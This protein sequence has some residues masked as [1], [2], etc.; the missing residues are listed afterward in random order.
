MDRIK[1]K[2]NAKKMIE[3][4]VWTLILPFFIA[5]LISVALNYILTGSSTNKA[6]ISTI[7]FITSCVVYPIQ[8]GCIAYVLKFVRREPINLKMIFSFYNKFI[9]IFALYFLTSLFSSIGFICLLIPGF[10]IVLGLTMGPYIMIDGTADPMECLRKSWEMMK[11]YKWDYL[12]FVFSFFWWYML[13]IITCGIAII[14]VQPYVMTAQTLY[15]EE[16]KKN[17]QK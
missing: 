13:I 6:Y 9:Y 16:L 2:N 7:S 3:G 14:Y 5:G 1:I 11:G 4:N 8:L 10:I 17:E 12:V 15:Y